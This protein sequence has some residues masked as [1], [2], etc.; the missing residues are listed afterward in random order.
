MKSIAFH[1]MVDK[2]RENGYMVTHTTESRIY[3][4]Y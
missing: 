3:V 1:V 4:W 2:E